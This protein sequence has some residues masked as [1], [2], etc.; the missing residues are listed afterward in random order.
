M[1]NWARLPLTTHVRFTLAFCGV[2]FVAAV[3]AFSFATPQDAV[4]ADT[5]QEATPPADESERE[6]FGK[7]RRGGGFDA[8]EDGLRKYR[9]SG[10]GANVNRRA[11]TEK[12]MKGL[13]E[14]ANDVA[15]EWAESLQK[16][17]NSNPESFPEYVRQHGRRLM[18]FVMLRERS[19]IL[20]QVRVDE[21]RCNRSINRVAKEYK[22]AVLDGRSEEMA[23][24]QQKLR[25]LVRQS[26]DLEL[27]ARAMELAELDRALK[28]LKAELEEEIATQTE[29]F[30]ERLQEVMSPDPEPAA[31]N[32]AI[33]S[34][35]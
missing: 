15:P 27:R 6:R 25:E 14:V 24:I 2:L 11:L 4:N 33:E 16:K 17:Y 5:Q 30:E 26:L 23:S 3:P 32:E 12:D 22:Q 7:R 31:D 28:Q 10:R 29:R 1:K 34:T 35:G 13:M 8:G 19:P 21:M 18:G 9:R 20:Y